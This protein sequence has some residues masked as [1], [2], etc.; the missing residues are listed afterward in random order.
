MISFEIHNHKGK[1]LLTFDSE[2]R[3]REQLARV[4]QIAKGARLM[5]VT[6]VME[7]LA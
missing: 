6:R 7:E 5:K 2:T 3:A 1:P 4:R